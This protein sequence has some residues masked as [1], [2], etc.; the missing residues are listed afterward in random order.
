[1]TNFYLANYIDMNPE[2]YGDAIVGAVGEMAAL[3]TQ[4]EKQ[5]EG[6]LPKQSYYQ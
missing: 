6:L 1:M 2:T 3:N 4:N 5:Q